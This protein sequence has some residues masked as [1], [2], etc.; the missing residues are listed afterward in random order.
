MQ[1]VVIL[2]LSNQLSWFYNAVLR[3][4]GH[5][6]NFWINTTTAPPPH[7][8][9]TAYLVLMFIVS[10]SYLHALTVNCNLLS[11]WGK[12]GKELGVKESIISPRN[13]RA[14]KKRDIG[15]KKSKNTFWIIYNKHTPL[16]RPPPTYS[17]HVS[18]QAKDACH[19]TLSQS[20]S[21]LRSSFPHRAG[22][23]F[24]VCFYKGTLLGWIRFS[25]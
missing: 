13:E 24:F 20:L 7:Q 14:K 17:N 12:K 18:L 8:R 22:R 6:N 21:T 4:R 10:S 15:G 3:S 11:T 23:D 5:Y 19:H 1:S 9:C 25:K 16:W 2:N